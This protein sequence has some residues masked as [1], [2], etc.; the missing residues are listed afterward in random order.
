MSDY[1]DETPPEDPYASGPVAEKP[2]TLTMFEQRVVGGAIGTPRIIPDLLR[3][4]AGGDFHDMRLG[5]IFRGVTQLHQDGVH[6]DY[7]AVYDQL[8]A[9][10]IRGVEL[11]DL[12]SWAETT[13]ASA[14]YYAGRVREASA[15]RLLA[16]IGARLQTADD[17]GVAMARATED[18]RRL[19]DMSAGG[20]SVRWLR[21]V[22]DVPEDEDAYDWV[23]PGLLERGD[24]MGLTA[25]EGAGKSTLLRQFAVLSA[26]GVHP[27]RGT[28]MDPV[29]VLVVDA[30]NSERQWRRK[31]RGLAFNAEMQGV[32]APQ[33]HLALHCVPVMDVARPNDL[34]QIHRWV[35]QA[36]P[37]LL[38]I[39]P[40]YRVAGGKTLNTDED[41]A[42]VLNAL[43]TIRDRGVTILIEMHAGHATNQSGERNLRPRGS[44]ALMGWPEFGLGIRRDKKVEG[45]VPTYSLVRWRGDRDS[46]NRDWPPRLVHGQFWPWEVAGW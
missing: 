29:N 36:K 10:D 33:D 18:L 40:L 26:A 39:G 7:L 17:V 1:I 13:A 38:V 32:R 4:V 5:A 15:R 8:E 31:T 6:I 37:D 20:K 46:D 22:L 25:G 9:W 19:R 11:T 12:A 35:D 28:R 45:R 30:E 41:A 27:L 14:V 21:E 42:P 16:D 2:D 24:R 3:E 43:D 44:A 23:I 34:G